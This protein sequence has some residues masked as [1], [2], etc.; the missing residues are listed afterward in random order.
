MDRM[1]DFPEPDLPISSTFFFRLRES[2]SNIGELCTGR[3]EMID[4]VKAAQ[5]GTLG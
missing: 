3:S 1:D 4:E 2:I 5:F